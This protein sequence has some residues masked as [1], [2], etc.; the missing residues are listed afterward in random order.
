V[1]LFALDGGD[2]KFAG[3]AVSDAHGRFELRGL[4]AGSYRVSAHSR[5]SGVAPAART[6]EVAEA[7][8]E[9]DLRL[10]AGVELVVRVTRADGAPAAGVPVAWTDANGATWQFTADDRTDAEGQLTIPGVPPGRWTITAA[11]AA[12]QRIDLE[13]GERRV[14]EFRIGGDPATKDKDKR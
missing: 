2:E 12:A 11:G 1:I 4:P 3:R 9:V 13:L 7:P 14:L 6:F 8:V 10:V 5:R